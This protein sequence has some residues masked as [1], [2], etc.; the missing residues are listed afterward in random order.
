MS[1]PFDFVRH[2]RDEIGDLD[3]NWSPEVKTTCVCGHSWIYHWLSEPHACNE[4]KACYGYRPAGKNAMHLNSTTSSLYKRWVEGVGSGGLADETFTALVKSYSEPHRKY[5]T[6]AHLEQC[7]DAADRIVPYKAGSDKNHEHTVFS[8]SIWYHDYVY[9]TQNH[10]NEELSVAAFQD[11]A[12]ILDL[13]RS[14]VEEVSRAILLTKHNDSVEVGTE[15]EAFVLDTD[16]SILGA[17][18]KTFEN[19]EQQ[20][21]EEYATIPTGIFW[22]KRLE[23][24]ERFVTKQSIYLTKVFR[25]TFETQA[26]VN[27]AR[28]MERCREKV[29]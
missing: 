10:G 12:F 20:I 23:I 28:A 7:F 27:L 16:L 22:T 6:L 5:H 29:A 4:C 9:F 18:Q 25:E 3:W 19:Y 15:V 1:D 24:L 2:I 11:R 21:R 14:V 13:D 17:D 8:L 26:R